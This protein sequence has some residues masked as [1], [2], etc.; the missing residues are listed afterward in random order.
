MLT[1]LNDD[2]CSP[3]PCAR[4]SRAPW[5]VVIP[6]TTMTTLRYSSSCPVQAS[7]PEQVPPDSG[8]RWAGPW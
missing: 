2:T 8:R 3:S 4:F 1:H 7:S 6:T 5:W